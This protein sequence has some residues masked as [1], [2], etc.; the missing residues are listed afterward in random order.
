MLFDPE[1]FKDKGHELTI[2]RHRLN[3]ETLLEYA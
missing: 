2:E 3:E 1:D